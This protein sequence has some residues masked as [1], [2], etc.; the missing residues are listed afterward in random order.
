MSAAPRPPRRF[1][2]SEFADR[3]APHGRPTA[4]PPPRGW[5]ESTA[6]R[7]PPSR[8]VS[9]TAVSQADGEA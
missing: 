3:P 9:E 2:A 7:T 8:P 4:P 5:R 6:Q 1:A